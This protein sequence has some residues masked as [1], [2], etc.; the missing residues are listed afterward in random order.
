MAGKGPGTTTEILPLTSI[1]GVAAVWVMLGHMLPDILR[2]LGNPQSSQLLSNFA[3]GNQFAV[4]IFFVLSGYIMLVAYGFHVDPP[5][6]YLNRFARVFPL[7]IVTLGVAIAGFYLLQVPPDPVANAPGNLVFYITLTSAWIGL[8]PAWNQPAWSLSV[9]VF[10][11]IFFPL[12]QLA[13]RN[14]NRSH[15]LLCVFLLCA[16]HTMV[17]TVIGFADTGIGALLRGILGFCAGVALCAASIHPIRFGP[18]IAVVAIAFAAAF[19]LYEYAIPAILLLIGALGVNKTGFFVRV[20]ST[21]VL[22]WLGKISYSIYLIHLPLLMG[23]G[24]IL[25]KIDFLQSPSGQAIFCLCYIAVV[26]VTAHLS[27]RFIETPARAAV[28]RLYRKT[29][30]FKTPQSQSSTASST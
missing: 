8:P 11:Y 20:M 10:A 21:Q 16:V 2:A 3:H 17:L 22:V 9:E 26:L 14:F 12:M 25:R 29:R 5:R 15:A 23:G 1:R 28:H 6:F 19:N 30:K 7:H 4:D 18:V 27:W 13:I 24:R